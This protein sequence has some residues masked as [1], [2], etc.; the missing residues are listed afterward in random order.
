MK[1]ICHCFY[2]CCTDTIQ[3][4]LGQICS[5]NIFLFCSL[6]DIYSEHIQG[7]S[8]VQVFVFPIQFAI[9]YLPVSNHVP[10][11]RVMPKN[12]GSYNCGNFLVL[13]CDSTRSFFGR[14]KVRA[15]KVARKRENFAEAFAIYSRR[16]PKLA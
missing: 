14:G 6:F 1:L 5:R 2:N 3:C 15:F 11:V 16:R 12:W 8:L 13:G 9:D 4:I 7:C 10:L